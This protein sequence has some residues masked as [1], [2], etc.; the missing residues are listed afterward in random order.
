[1]GQICV[2]IG[3]FCSFIGHDNVADIL[4]HA[5][6]TGTDYY[7]STTITTTTTTTTTVERGYVCQFVSKY[8]PFRML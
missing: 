5:L 6:H 4:A 3:N 8:I 1:M 7:D 2:S